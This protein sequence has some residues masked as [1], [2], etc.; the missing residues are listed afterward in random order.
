MQSSFAKLPDKPLIPPQFRLAVTGLSRIGKTSFCNWLCHGVQTV[1][2]NKTVRFRFDLASFAEND[3]ELICVDCPG[4]D[5][6]PLPKAH[7]RALDL[8]V[9]IY[10]P[11]S[12]Y[13]L[14]GF[15]AVLQ[16]ILPLMNDSAQTLLLGNTVKASE[17]VIDVEQ[18]QEVADKFKSMHMEV[19]LE[20]CGEEIIR[21]KVLEMLSKLQF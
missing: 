1:D 17:R 20:S 10:S 7:L 5:L 21:A 9:Y 11:S 3:C 14:D 15:E 13:S 12:E 18:A 4:I 6:E 8:L 19:C 2:H 16:E